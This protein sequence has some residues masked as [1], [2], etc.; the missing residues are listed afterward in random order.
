MEGSLKAQTGVQ[1]VNDVKG[2]IGDTVHTVTDG[3]KQHKDGIRSSV[4]DMGAFAAH[5]AHAIM[6]SGTTVTIGIVAILGTAVIVYLLV[7]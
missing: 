3:F 6:P 4:E 1:T 7:N 5:G 2:A